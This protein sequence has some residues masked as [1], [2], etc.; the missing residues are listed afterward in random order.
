MT[1]ARETPV[2][3]GAGHQKHVVQDRVVVVVVVVGGVVVWHHPVTGA[4]VPV[5]T[6]APTLVPLAERKTVEMNAQ[7]RPRELWRLL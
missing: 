5:D 6:G 3:R 4:G 2:T 7:K 1:R